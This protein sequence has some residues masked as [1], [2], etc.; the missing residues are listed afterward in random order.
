MKE[1]KTRKVGEKANR[2]QMWRVIISAKGKIGKYRQALIRKS[3][4]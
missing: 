2:E 3:R 1:K 4:W